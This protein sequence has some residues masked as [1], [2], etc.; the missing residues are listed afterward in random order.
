LRLAASGK[1][2]ENSLASFGF[3]PYRSK[4]NRRNSMQYGTVKKWDAAK[5]FGFIVSDDDDELFVHKSG[6]DATVSNQQLKVGQRVAFD[7][8][9]E[10]KGDRA[11]RVKVAR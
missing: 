7:I 8:V 2:E 1:I 5:G 11:V 10:M 6:L 3:L 4:N 9:R